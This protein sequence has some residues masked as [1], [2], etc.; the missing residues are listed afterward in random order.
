MEEIV[1][2]LTVEMH[3]LKEV[4]NFSGLGDPKPSV[5]CFTLGDHG[6]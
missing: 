6:P 5:L 4:L 1:F 3:K 2:L